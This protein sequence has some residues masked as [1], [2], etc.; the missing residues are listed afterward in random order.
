LTIIQKKT[1]L[2]SLFANYFVPVNSHLKFHRGRRG[3]ILY[4]KKKAVE[5]SPGKILRE[6][7]ANAG[8]NSQET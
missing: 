5:L 8:Q 7:E 3:G 6:G 4:E 1:I 2:S